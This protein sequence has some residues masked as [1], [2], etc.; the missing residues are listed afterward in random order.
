MRSEICQLDDSERRILGGIIQVSAATLSR[1]LYTATYVFLTLPYLVFFGGWIRQ[2]YA[3]IL[4][5]LLL[6]GTGLSIRG[7]LRAV[8]DIPGERVTGRD[9]AWTL[10]PPALLVLFTGTGGW[11]WQDADWL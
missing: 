1:S 9:L 3:T 5:G 4:I 6:V 8:Q 11:G 2:P 7:A 10:V